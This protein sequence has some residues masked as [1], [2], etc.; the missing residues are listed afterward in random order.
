MPPFMRSIIARRFS[1]SI[2]VVQVIQAKE[3]A[4]IAP[5]HL[6]QTLFQMKHAAEQQ[7]KARLASSHFNDIPFQVLL[8]HGDPVP[9]ISALVDQNS[10]DLVVTGSHGR[11]GTY[12]LL[13]PSADQAITRVAACP[14]LLIGPKAAT[15]PE[16]GGAFENLLFVPRISLRNPGARWITPMRWQKLMEPICISST[17]QKTSGASRFRPECRRRH[18]V[19]CVFLKKAGVRANKA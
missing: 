14:A 11:H 19:A 13:S 12:K 8:E 16:R 17:L 2:Y 6:D 7:I 10:I 3:Y 15:E 4:H 18:S 1:S 5:D 9:V